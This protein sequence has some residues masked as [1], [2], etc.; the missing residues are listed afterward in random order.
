MEQCLA[1]TLSYFQK[2]FILQNTLNIQCFSFCYLIRNWRSYA[3]EG[4][5]VKRYLPILV[6]ILVRCQLN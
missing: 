1:F 2:K 6:T 4:E 5:D 3:N